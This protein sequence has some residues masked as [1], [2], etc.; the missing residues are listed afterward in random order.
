MS[1]KVVTPGLVRFS[2]ANV[3]E[4]KAIQQGQAPKYSC[5]ILVP[6]TDKKTIKA[7]EKGIEEAKE[8]GKVKLGGKIPANLK[9]PLRDGD[10]E[11]PDDE[12]YEGM[13]FF[14]ANAT[15][16]PQVIDTSG[17]LIFDPA[18]FYSGC[19]GRAS[20][21]FY[22]YNTNGNKGIAAGLNNLLKVKDGDRL[23]G[24]ST[25]AEDFGDMTFED[26]DLG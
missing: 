23:G 17:N 7:I 2:Y 20:V 11:R 15:T 14:N 13:M 18:E 4:A 22:A 19:W 9:T 12:A 26:E 16:K 10:E 5:S 6:K 1:I 25:A 24:G 3:F 8:E 21:S